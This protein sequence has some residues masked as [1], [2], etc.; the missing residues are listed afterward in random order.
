[1]TIRLAVVAVAF[2]AQAA[3]AQEQ[4]PDTA[5]VPTVIVTATRV[6]LNQS[7]L[8]VAVSV[9]TNEELRVRGITTVAD[10]LQDVTSA[11]VTQ[12]GS[13]GATTS[14]FLRGGESKY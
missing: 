12:A 7:A 10:A 8:P 3:L 9:I 4:S 14:L 13:Q 5:R 2:A 1:M 11:Y 6:P